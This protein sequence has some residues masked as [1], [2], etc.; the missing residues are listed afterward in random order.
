MIKNFFWLIIFMLLTT[1]HLFA[2]DNYMQVKGDSLVGKTVDGEMI[3]EVYGDVVVTQGNVVITCNQ[4]TQFISRNEAE[5]IGN[6]ILKQDSLTITTAKG[7]YYGDLKESVSDTAIKLDDGKVTLTAKRGRYY[8]DAHRA[9]FQD[10]VKLRDSV[11]V[12]TSDSLT[13]YRDENRMVA[14]SNVTIVDTASSIMADSLEHFRKTRVTYAYHNIKAINRANHLIMFGDHLEDFPEQQYTMV[15]KNPVLLQIDTTYVQNSD[16]LSGKS[17]ESSDSTMQIDSLLIKSK[18]MEAYRDTLDYFKATDSVR[19]IRGDFAS[20]NNL[21]LYFR[22]AGQIVT[23]KTADSTAQPYLWYENTQLTGDSVTI[24]L[25]HNRIHY[26]KVN[27]DAYIIS[28][29]EDYHNRFDQTSGDSVFMTFD[30]SRLQKTNIWGSMFSIYYQYDGT[31]PNGLTKSSAQNAIINFADNKVD[32]IRMYGSP[33]S[34][35]YP[36]RLVKGKE[37]T[38]VLAKYVAFRTKPDKESIIKSI[39]GRWR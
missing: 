35:F 29:N 8:F 19:I 34:E 24:F 27:K 9:F 15:D 3:R 14:V 1:S 28:Q 22:K 26:L 17:G 2:Q 18:L 6:V 39:P 20:V 37:D 10:S 30:N 16:S 12:L 36:E 33:N 21:T 5:L 38:F 32:E 23:Y 31:T 13:Y 7:Y 25:D 11:S 4:A